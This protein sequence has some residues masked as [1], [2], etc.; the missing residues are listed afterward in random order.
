MKTVRV[1]VIYPLPEGWG[2]CLS[3]EMVMAH[4]NLGQAP[5]ERGLEEYPPEWQEEFRRLSAMILDLSER[6]QNR[7]MIH[8]WDP[9]S[10]QGLAKSI[11]YGA[12]SYPT[13]IVDGH[14]K[15]K[16]WDIQEVER[17]IQEVDGIPQA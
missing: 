16:G 13:F 15:V 8:I 6:Y 17:F 9:R 12:R 3:C 2:I 11:R 14:W 10:L 4:A 1:D 7:I 5:Y